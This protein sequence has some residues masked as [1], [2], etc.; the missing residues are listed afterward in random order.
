MGEKTNAYRILVGKPEEWR[1][2]GRSRRRQDINIKM[3]RRELGCGGMSWL[4]W[5]RIEPPPGGVIL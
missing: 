3:D 2:L 1:P 4:Y 5:L